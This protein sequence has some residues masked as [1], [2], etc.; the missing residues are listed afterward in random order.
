MLDQISM[1]VLGSGSKGNAYYVWNNDTAVLIDCGLST[2]QI[3]SRLE[4]LGFIQPKIDAVFVTHEHTDHVSGCAILERRLNALGQNTQFYMSRGTYCSAPERCLPNNFT[5]MCDGQQVK[6]GTMV[7]EGF[8]VPHDGTE[9]LGYRV[10]YKEHWAGVITDL[11]VVTD[12]VLNKMRTLSIMAFEFNH[13]EHML[14]NGSYPFS[15]KERILDWSGHLS[16]RQAAEAL[17]HAVSP[18]L[19]H[20]ILAHISEQ[21]N[22]PELAE[23]MARRVLDRAGHSDLVSL[24]VA[25]QS[26]PSP[27]FSIHKDPIAKIPMAML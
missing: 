17:E 23:N 10:G 8:E 12:E 2:K 26:G 24:H 7:V 4:L 27:I 5:F 25:N 6:I 16:N 15:V 1:V 9:C 19:Q 3:F 14:I 21:N 13:D 11:G 20:L 18:R 22:C